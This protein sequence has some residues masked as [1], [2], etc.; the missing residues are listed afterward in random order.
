[1]QAN[2]IYSLIFAFIVYFI[3][4]NKRKREEAEQKNEEEILRSSREAERQR[5]RDVE[6]Q[7][8][9]SVKRKGGWAKKI[10]KFKEKLIL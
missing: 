4:R 7:E 6:K 10:E 9:Y 8:R 2:I 5:I 1:M 3:I